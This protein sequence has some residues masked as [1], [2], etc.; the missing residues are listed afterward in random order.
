MASR[1]ND[2]R[3]SIWVKGNRVKIV[4]KLF[5]SSNVI[6]TQRYYCNLKGLFLISTLWLNDYTFTMQKRLQKV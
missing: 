6:A 2:P 5:H 1:V 3:V 4:I